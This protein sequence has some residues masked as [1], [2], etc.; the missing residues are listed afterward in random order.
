MS[1]PS[2]LQLRVVLLAVLAAIG[3]AVLLLIRSARDGDAPVRD[4]GEARSRV[5]RTTRRPAPGASGVT[6]QPAR[7][8]IPTNGLPLALATELAAHP[9]V[10]VSLF[11]PGTPVDRIA[12]TEARAGAA[13][14]GAG[15]VALNVRNDAQS[16]PLVLE[17]GVLENPAVLVYR[18]PKDVLLRIDG[19]ADR[20]TVAQA[21]ANAASTERL[22][23]R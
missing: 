15:F 5:E 19:Y 14:A 1:L 10:V 6:L 11:A 17:L 18:R 20:E 2:S 21:A 8:L 9:V 3:L 13:A 12:L 7:R 22:G 16:R 23:A 4:V